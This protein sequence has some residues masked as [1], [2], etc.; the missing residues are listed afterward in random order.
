MHYKEKTS[1][2]QC[3]ALTGNFRT[4]LKISEHFRTFQN[5][6]LQTKSPKKTFVSQ[7]P[8]TY[9]HKPKIGNKTMQNHAHQALKSNLTN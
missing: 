4:L 8:Q 1:T 7:A 6:T 3:K 5:Q 2:N 9:P